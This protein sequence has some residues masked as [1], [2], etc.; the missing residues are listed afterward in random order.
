MTCDRKDIQELIPL[1]LEEVLDHPD[2]KLVEDHLGACGDCRNEV[3]VLRSLAAD[4]VP[5]PGEAFWS[6]MPG[7]V[8]RAVAEENRAG[9]SRWRPAWLRAFLQPS[10]SWGAAAV[11]MAAVVSVLLFRSG[12]TPVPPVAMPAAEDLLASQDEP[13]DLLDVASIG[14]EEITEVDAWA[15]RQLA[16]LGSE[17]G[18]VLESGNVGELYEEIADLDRTSLERLSRMLDS[19][20]KE[21]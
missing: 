4:P 2:R 12:D 10:W 19:M 17:A 18:A 5:D 7:R 21:G 1:Y 13:A 15:E 8:A 9:A 3:A 14:S 11:A 20:K 6:A 16:D